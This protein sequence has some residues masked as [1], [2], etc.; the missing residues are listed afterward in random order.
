VQVGGFGGGAV[1]KSE[2]VFCIYAVIVLQAFVG[3]AGIGWELHW[4]RDGDAM[5]WG[6]PDPKLSLTALRK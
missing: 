3:F 6:V 2:C 1:L 4:G 5:V